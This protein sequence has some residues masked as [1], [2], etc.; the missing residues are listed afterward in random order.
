MCIWQWHDIK[1]KAY[2]LPYA[3]SALGSYLGLVWKPLHSCAA[4]TFVL[5][6]VSW[7]LCWLQ[8]GTEKTEFMSLLVKPVLNKKK[9]H[10]F[11][12]CANFEVQDKKNMQHTYSGRHRMLWTSSCKCLEMHIEFS[13]SYRWTWSWWSFRTGNVMCHCLG[14]LVDYILNWW[15]N[16]C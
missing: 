8:L 4:V 9:I 13:P 1:K 2:L 12:L 6:A 11:S 14:F 10:T 3:Q 15:D 16:P 7:P 5:T